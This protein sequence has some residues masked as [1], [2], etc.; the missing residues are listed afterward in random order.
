MFDIDTAQGH[1]KFSHPE[2]I[3]YILGPRAKCHWVGADM[4]CLSGLSLIHKEGLGDNMAM[5]DGEKSDH[6][7][8]ELKVRQWGADCFRVHSRQ[9][10][11]SSV[12][13]NHRPT[14]PEEKTLHEDQRPWAIKLSYTSQS[15]QGDKD[16]GERWV[17]VETRVLCV[18]GALAF[19]GPKSDKERTGREAETSANRAN[20]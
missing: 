12:K 2:F 3:I 4:K 11:K 17:P 13:N 16:W 6:V 1:V 9:T 8:L 5:M 20:C 18:G 14:G 10:S 15:F 19:I 7:I